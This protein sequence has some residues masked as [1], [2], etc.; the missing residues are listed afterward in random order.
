MSMNEATV[1]APKVR[2][3]RQPGLPKGAPPGTPRATTPWAKRRHEPYVQCAY[4]KAVVRPALCVMRNHW[5]KILKALPAD[6][7][8]DAADGVK[9]LWGGVVGDHSK[10]A[11]WQVIRCRDLAFLWTAVQEVL[12][13]Q[14]E[15]APALMVLEEV[16]RAVAYGA[17]QR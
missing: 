2:P 14:P 11:E 6:R 3:P 10:T 4:T 13:A 5:R 15:G 16:F 12:A 9:L 7:A 8:A 1:V 17:A